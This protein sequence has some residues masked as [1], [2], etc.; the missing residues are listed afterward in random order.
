MQKSN[1]LNP[2]RPVCSQFFVWTKIENKS[3]ETVDFRFSTAWRHAT[4][5]KI[6][7]CSLEHNYITCH[8]SLYANI[9]SFRRSSM[10]DT[11]ARAWFL[12]ILFRPSS[13][14]RIILPEKTDVACLRFTRFSTI[15]RIFSALHARHRSRDIYVTQHYHIILSNRCG[16]YTVLSETVFW[17]RPSVDDDHDVV[18]NRPATT[19]TKPRVTVDSN[20][21]RFKRCPCNYTYIC[22]TFD[23]ATYPWDML[24][25]PVRRDFR[26]RGQGLR[27]RSRFRPS[28]FS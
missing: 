17:R 26:A 11:R 4:I 12:R 3:K 18:A 13:L 2:N 1:R 28:R 20:R 15:A 10:Y 7:S 23:D 22:R 19:M 9:I 24:T 27:S 5:W 14:H 25:T 16:T 8:E 6:I 21:G